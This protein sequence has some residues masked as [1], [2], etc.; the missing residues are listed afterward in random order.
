MPALAPEDFVQIV[1]TETPAEPLRARAWEFAQAVIEHARALG[2]PEWQTSLGLG[3][4]VS[5]ETWRAMAQEGAIRN[6]MNDPHR[7]RGCTRSL[8]DLDMAIGAMASEDLVLLVAAG[9][10]PDSILRSWG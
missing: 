4:V 6:L 7:Y 2:M 1:P 3:R 8:L 10:L 5:R 9:I